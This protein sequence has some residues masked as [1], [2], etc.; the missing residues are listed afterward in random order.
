MGRFSQ[1]ISVAPAP[2]AGRW[3][4]PTRWR[5][6]TTPMSPQGSPTMP[7]GILSAFFPVALFALGG[8]R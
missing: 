6:I 5:I 1:L 2:P 8:Q 4:V 7:Y 3:F